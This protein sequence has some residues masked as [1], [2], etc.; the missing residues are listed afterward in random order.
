MST[1]VVFDSALPLDDST[2]SETIGTASSVELRR[3]D[4]MLLD[5]VRILRAAPRLQGLKI[6]GLSML[7]SGETGTVVYGQMGEL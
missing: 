5:V 2:L 1:R 6:T 7:K 3:D 4:V